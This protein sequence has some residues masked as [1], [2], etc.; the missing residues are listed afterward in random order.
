V[1][2]VTEHE[3]ADGSPVRPPEVV[4]VLDAL[5][6]AR[7]ATFWSAAMHYRRLDPLEQYEILVPPEGHAG[8][9]FLVQQVPEPKRTKNRM[10]IDLHVPDPDSEADRLV[11]LGAERRGRASLGDIHWITMADPEGNEFDIGKQ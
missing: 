4:L 6:P 3:L 7:L 2:D 8:F 5:D 10:H 11:A 9:M 1:Q